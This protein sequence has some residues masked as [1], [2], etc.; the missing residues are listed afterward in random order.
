MGGVGVGVNLGVGVGVGVKVG[1][2]VGVGLGNEPDEPPDEWWSL[3]V[4]EEP[5]DE[6][7]DD[8]LE[9][10]CNERC[11]LLEDDDPPDPDDVPEPEGGVAEP[12]AGVVGEAD[13]GAV[14]TVALIDSIGADVATLCSPPLFA[15]CGVLM[16]DG[17]EVTTNSEPVGKKD[18]QIRSAQKVTSVSSAAMIAP[19]RHSARFLYS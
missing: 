1:V 11:D 9:E 13:P 18:C 10:P 16:G 2:G 4:D 7:L 3:S 19:V 17:Y 8:D 6:P 12:E 5:P 14:D 15:L